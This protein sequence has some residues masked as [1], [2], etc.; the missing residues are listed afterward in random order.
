MNVP[1]TSCFGTEPQIINYYYN[2]VNGTRNILHLLY[3]SPT[4]HGISPDLTVMPTLTLL[5]NCIC[6]FTSGAL[7]KSC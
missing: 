1:L 2:Q 3:K 7:N 6:W 4:L 5:A